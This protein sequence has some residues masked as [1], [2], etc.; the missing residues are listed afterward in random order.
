MASVNAVE[1][2]VNYPTNFYGLLNKYKID[3][4]A[5][6]ESASPSHTM[7]GKR[8]GSY[9][10]PISEQEAFI[11]AYA[12][13]AFLCAESRDREVCIVER[14]REYGP[15]VIDLD[16]RYDLPVSGLTTRNHDLKMMEKFVFEYSKVLSSWIVFPTEGI[17]VYI[18]ERPSPRSDKGIVKDG[19]HVVI[20]DVVTDCRVQLCIRKECLAFCETLFKDLNLKNTIEDAFDEAVIQRNGW[21]MFGSS[22]IGAS[23][24]NVTRVLHVSIGDDGIEL[25]RV[26]F[27]TPDNLGDYTDLVRKLSIRRNREPDCV[28]VHP[29]RQEDLLRIKKIEEQT[30]RMK[31]THPDLQVV[32]CGVTTRS[33]LSD[34]VL[35]KKLVQILSDYRADEFGSWMRVGWCLHNIDDRLLPDWIEFSRRS[36]KFEEG[37]CEDVWRFMRVRTDR[38]LKIGSLRKWAQEDSP[39]E[40]EQITKDLNIDYVRKAI[41]G[42]HH[43]MALATYNVFHGE[44]VCSNVK[45]NTWYRFCGH[46]WKICESGTVLRSMLSTTMFDLFKEEAN[47]VSRSADSSGAASDNPQSMAA[48]RMNKNADRLKCSS[49]KDSVMKELRDQFYRENFEEMLDAKCHLLGFENGVYDLDAKEFRD[50]MP[51]DMITY[52]TRCNYIPFDQSDPAYKTLEDLFSTVQPDPRMKTYLVRFLASCLHGQI[53]EH[54]FHIAQGVGSNGKS[55]T[56][57]FFERAIG[58]YAVKLSVSFLT[59]K[60]GHSSAANPEVIRLKGKR[61]A[62]MQEPGND[63]TLN[64]G[65]MKEITGGDS[66]VARGLYRDCI[67]FKPQFRLLLT[68]NDLPEIKSADLGTWRRVKLLPFTSRFIEDP[69]P[70]KVNEFKIDYDLPSKIKEL[71]PYMVSLLIE[72][73][74]EYLEEGN[75]PPDQVTAATR[76]YK[77]RSDVLQLFIDK[78]LILD[79]SATTDL[80]ELFGMYKEFV[81]LENNGIQPKRQE[82][83]ANIRNVLRISIN[84]SGAAEGI[85][86]KK[87]ESTMQFIPRPS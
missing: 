76:D 81:V 32:E 18:M 15:V 54:S 12:A 25:K 82:F 65:L 64:I 4:K 87:E 27:V 14:H 21:M 67:E 74:Y 52:S 2:R 1:N 34:F 79:D 7:F 71:A 16:F 35:A 56:F 29:S 72:T 51:E 57:D 40:Y 50:G 11:D 28:E 36:A 26:P 10:I 77:R 80:D 84:A 44:Y 42:L 31:R 86:I 59:Q 39:Y 69:D 41:S 17:N 37:M 8:N 22:K 9:K 78:H 83:F 30:E 20:P 3:T 19:V 33:C 48:D 68:A 73:Y 46:R 23:P 62:C 5:S 38:L 55:L 45:S 49:F 13:E 61:F 60:R 47:M 24:Y 53:R 70:T 63:E 58:D 75:S 43:D 6:G 85:K 66:I